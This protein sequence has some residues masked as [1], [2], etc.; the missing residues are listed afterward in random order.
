MVIVVR[1]VYSNSTLKIMLTIFVLP[2][3]SPIELNHTHSHILSG[4]SIY[5]VLCSDEWLSMVIFSPLGP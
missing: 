3:K 1:L 2:K 4:Q 5:A